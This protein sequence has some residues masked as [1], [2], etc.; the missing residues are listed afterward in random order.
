M[1]VTIH[2]DTFIDCAELHI[3]DGTVI[4]K[5]CEIYGTRV[6]LGRD[7]FLDEYTVIGGGSAHDPNASLVAGDFLMTGMFSQLNI[8]AGL[9]IG[10][11]V[12]IGIQVRVFT[13]GAWL[14]EYDGFPCNFEATHIGDR[15]WIPEGMVMAG[16]HIGND[17]VVGAGSVVRG[18]LPD[19]CFAAGTPARVLREN[20]YPRVLPLDTRQEILERICHRARAGAVLTPDTIVCDGT[21]FLIPERQIDGEVTEDTERLRNQLRRH[22]IRFRYTADRKYQPWE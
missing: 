13:H 10:D 16:A 2:P 5:G 18:A 8:G 17:V 11:E 14:S 20:A 3:G 6:V 19:G 1:G 15:V 9:T 12:G 4:R 7:T 22:G 21:Y